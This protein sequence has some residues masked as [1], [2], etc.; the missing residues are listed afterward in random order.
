MS[1]KQTHTR[2]NI[3]ILTIEQHDNKTLYGTSIHSATITSYRV[4]SPISVELVR[5]IHGTDKASTKR[6]P[7]S[8]KLSCPPTM[9]LS[10]PGQA[11]MGPDPN[12]CGMSLAADPENGSLTEVLDT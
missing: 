3:R 9:A 5:S 4:T 1:I 10:L 6:P 8:R 2:W 11:P 7:L 12:G